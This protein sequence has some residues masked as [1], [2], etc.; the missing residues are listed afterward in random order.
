MDR[1]K[2]KW[3]APTSRTETQVN[4][5]KL[6]AWLT[7]C[8]DP[9]SVDTRPLLDISIATGITDKR[10]YGEVLAG[11]LVKIKTANK[12]EAKHLCQEFNHC[13]RQGLVLGEIPEPII[14]TALRSVSQRLRSLKLDISETAMLYMEFFSLIW[15]GIRDCKV[16]RPQDMDAQIFNRLLYGMSE[17]RE[18]KFDQIQVMTADILKF[19][20]ASQL[21]SMSRGIEAVTECWAINWLDQSLEVD[22]RMN[23]PAPVLALSKILESLPAEFAE[24]IIPKITD[25]VILAVR[26]RKGT[27]LAH[28]KTFKLSWAAM[29]ANMPNVSEDLFVNTWQTLDTSLNQEFRISP[30]YTSP[31]VSPFTYQE[32]IALGIEYWISHGKFRQSTK[33]RGSYMHKRQDKYHGHV[34]DLLAAID[35]RRDCC[36]TQARGLFALFRRVRLD[37]VMPKTLEYLPKIGL[38]VPASL[39][40]TE[41]RELALQ[42]K[43]D[44]A[45]QMYKLYHTVRFD[46]KPLKVDGLPEFIT[47]LISSPN[48][49][50]LQVWGICRIPLA[51]PGAEI[52]RPAQRERY[53][54]RKPVRKLEKKRVILI[55][56]MA[57]AFADAEHLY[58]AASNCPA[59]RNV[60][61]C[62]RYLCLY[63]EKPSVEVSRA[64]VQIGIVK[65]LKAGHGPSTERLRWVLRYVREAEGDEVA[66][67]I[68]AYVQNFREKR[69]EQKMERRR[70]Q[71]PLGLGIID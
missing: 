11:F 40:A 29:V 22:L 39:V 54:Y 21:E 16:L 38:K 5:P 20:S 44:V 7:D 67:D 42:N 47:G 71:N 59:Y 31:K 61:Q 23:I 17:L 36:W 32:G 4:K 52:R 28:L 25:Q 30:S 62:V 9:A 60:R 3:E 69:I 14:V 63:N 57:Q 70:L 8:E 58:S 55:Q 65:P 66:H 18:F 48:I 64:L 45:L 33:V 50:P 68:D 46:N 26:K 51:M 41:I 1:T 53:R 37:D 56:K 15:G 12:Q 49:H 24:R 6:P 13:F 27:K 19:M 2:W 34:A 43:L 35:R 10:D